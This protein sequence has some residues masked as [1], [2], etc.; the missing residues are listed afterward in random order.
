MS[1]FTCEIHDES[2]IAALARLKQ[3]PVSKVIRNA[4]RDFARAAQKE[5]PLA[6]VSRSEY[7]R[8]WDERTRGW[9]YLHQSQVEESYVSRTGAT[10]MR[11]R[12]SAKSRFAQLKRVRVHKGWSKASWIGVFRELGLPPKSRG[13][14][15]EEVEGLSQATQT[16]TDYYSEMTIDDA[17]HFDRFGRNMSASTV[18]KIAKAGYEA[19]AKNITKETQRML[20]K[21]WKGAK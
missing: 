6:S 4:G 13:R 21:Q 12:K 7:Y 18:E 19:A 5:T 14:L 11:V 10:R 2:M 1:D 3:I 8:Y 16:A 17:I 15:S 9:K 20:E